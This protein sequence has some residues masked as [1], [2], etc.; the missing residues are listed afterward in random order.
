[1]SVLDYEKSRRAPEWQPGTMVCSDSGTRY[2]I[3]VLRWYQPWQGW[4]MHGEAAY[5]AVCQD[6]TERRVLLRVGSREPAESEYSLLLAAAWSG[7][8]EEDA[9]HSFDPVNWVPS[10]RVAHP[11]I[12]GMLETGRIG[13]GDRNA[14]LWTADK[15]AEQSFPFAALEWVEGATLERLLLGAR[16]RVGQPL[17][18]GAAL[19]LGIVIADALAWIHASETR[20]LRGRTRLSHGR[21]DP[22]H[23]F[24]GTDGRCRLMTPMRLFHHQFRGGLLGFGVPPA[25]DPACGPLVDPI[26]DPATDL[27]RLG[28]VLFEICTGRRWKAAD[29]RRDAL[30]PAPTGDAAAA[31]EAMSLG[32]LGSVTPPGLAAC[33]RRLLA[34]EAGEKIGSA[35]E[36]HAALAEASTH[37]TEPRDEVA[38]AA[39]VAVLGRPPPAGSA[40]ETSDS[41]PF[42]CLGDGRDGSRESVT[43]KYTETS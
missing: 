7:V 37:C 41:V 23:V 11:A 33:I 14:G 28:A 30:S 10:P 26:A 18:A 40:G 39:A 2:R 42:A 27:A 21:L 3:G 8:V 4:H 25:C 43:L 35:R 9:W 15:A 31:D 20:S 19:T 16:T 38:I 22:Q 12:A 29:S 6:L 13:E 5:E 36:A 32:M 34:T 1:L 24:V 17:G